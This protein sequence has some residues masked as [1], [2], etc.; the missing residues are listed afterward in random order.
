MVV[1]STLFVAGSIA[2]AVMDGLCCAWK[3]HDEGRRRAQFRRD[4]REEYE[5]HR[6][7]ELRLWEERL[8]MRQ[9]HRQ[10]R[11]QQKQFA[12]ADLLS[13]SSSSS[14]SSD[15][16]DEDEDAVGPGAASASAA[17]ERRRILMASKMKA[18]AAV[19]GPVAGGAAGAGAGA[20]PS[21]SRREPAVEDAAAV[22]RGH[23]DFA[24]GAG[25]ESAAAA[26]RG[27]LGCDKYDDDDRDAPCPLVLDDSAD[28]GEVELS[29]VDV[30]F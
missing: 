11:Q 17:E 7:A 18:S 15:S 22:L 27:N 10:H 13:L 25:D 28:S 19:A 24:D 6:R 4:L 3:S 5:R 21:P 9:K 14:P 8:A 1:D 20:A 2:S 12:H 26:R 30:P 29:L 16:E 23:R